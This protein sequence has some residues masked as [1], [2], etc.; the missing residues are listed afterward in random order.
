M[1]EQS[2][3]GC[4]T[5]VPARARAPSFYLP[6]N[7]KTKGS[8]CALQRASPWGPPGA[9]TSQRD[10][11]GLSDVGEARDPPAYQGH[12]CVR[13]VRVPGWLWAADDDSGGQSGPQTSLVGMGLAGC[14]GPALGRLCLGCC[15]QQQAQGWQGPAPSRAIGPQPARKGH[16]P[17]PGVLAFFPEPRWQL[18]VHLWVMGEE[19]RPLPGR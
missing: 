6:R 10:G 8:A 9:G 12:A 4:V 16:M 1:G 11:G 19:G 13:D 14:R 2:Q 18:L 7:H 15:P 3:V 5:R 17:Y